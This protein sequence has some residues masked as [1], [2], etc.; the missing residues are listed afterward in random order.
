MAKILTNKDWSL[1]KRFGRYFVPHKKWLIVSLSSIPVTTTASILFLWLVERIIDDYIVP[2]DVTGLKTY[3]LFLA[4]VLLLNLL[5]D[6]VYSY[7]FSKAGGLAIVDMRRELFG[8]AIRF[9]MRYYDKHP[10]GVTL[11]RLTSD[12]ESISESFAA[13]ILG[14]LSESIKTTALVGYLFYLNWRLTLVLLIV[15]PLI[16]LV[17]RYLRRKIRAAYDESRTSLA[18]SAAYLQESLNGMKTIQLYNA[19]DEAWNK[20]NNLNQTYCNAQNRSNVYDSALYSIVEGITSVATA[21]VLFYGAIQVWD[22]GYTMGVLVVF[23]T[24]LGRL[25]I[26]VRQFA[27]QISTIQRALSALDHISH[28][29]EQETEEVENETKKEGSS[30]LREIRFENVSFRYSEDAPDVLKNISFTLRKGDRIALVGTTGS[31]KSTIIRLLTKTY[32]GYRG[33]I[34]INGRELRD[35]PLAEIRN[36]MALMQQD[37]FMFNDSIRFNIALGREYLTEEDIQKAASF[38]YA[39]HFINQL[40]GKMEYVIQD[41]GDNLSKGQGQLISFA[42]AISGNNELIILDEATSAVDSLTENYIQKAIE[43][44]FSSRTV[45]AVAH[46]LSTIKHSDQILVLEQGRIIERGNH[47]ELVSQGGK[48]AG[49]VKTWEEKNTDSSLSE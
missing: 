27:Q 28:L 12:M 5:F 3:A 15:V 49:L 17:M 36:M 19:E 6:G 34:Q 11:S 14:L 24:T 35:I 22:Y 9:P 7:T 10:I 20:Y 44:I 23:I 48:Y 45:I 42:R 47:D 37:I 41:N 8:K 26:P 31:G 2:G 16:V 33:S 39:D 21:L 1:I 43:N 30:E 4:G 32:T 13:G 40:P 46:R 18:K 29:F 38:V 25:F